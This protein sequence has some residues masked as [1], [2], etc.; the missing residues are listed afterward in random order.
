MKYIFLF[1]VPFLFFG[2]MSWQADMSQIEISKITVWDSNSNRKRVIDDFNELQKI[3]K[4]WQQLEPIDKLPDREWACS[5]DIYAN[6]LESSWLYNKNGYLARLNYEL[7]PK[8]RVKDIA[9]F[10]ELILAE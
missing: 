3:N 8:F 9:A 7:K 6:Q 2:C 5:I 4:I 10:N 1:L